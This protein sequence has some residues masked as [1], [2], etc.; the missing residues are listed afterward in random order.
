MYMDEFDLQIY[1]RYNPDISHLTDKN[2]LIH[3]ET[4]GKYEKRIYS[5]ESMLKKSEHL[6]YFDLDHYIKANP[7][8]KFETHNEYVLDYLRNRLNDGL[9]IN[10][11]LTNFK[12]L[13]KE[14]FLPL[15]KKESKNMN[16]LSEEAKK[17][18][19]IGACDTE[20][21]NEWS[22]SEIIEQVVS[23]NEIVVNIGAG[24][25][26]NKERYYSLKNVINTEIFA[27]PTTDI[28]CDGDD[29][30]FKDNSVDAIISLAVLEHVKNPWKH[31]EEMLRVVKPGGKILADVPFLQPYHGY[32]YHYYNMTTEG[33]RNLFGKNVK[34]LSHT[35]E[36]WEKPIH[37]LTWFLDRY[38]NFLTNPHTR[39]RFLNLTVQEILNNGTNLELDYVQHMDKSKEEI[40]A[41]GSC[42]IVEK[43]GD[44]ES[45]SE[46][47]TTE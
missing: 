39:L 44:F 1:K 3:W 5:K 11:E 24:Y 45:N 19:K 9:D 40:I 15:L 36:N 29:L 38:K 43:L 12:N 25:R 30:P 35:I 42:L 22:P 27:Y 32:P 4:N 2:L 28:V 46:N 16:F 17:I 10:S 41:C 34:I 37:T 7:D 18:Y 8:I 6:L 47:N 14:K 31:V 23:Q 33:L 20:S 13:K 26:K 21:A